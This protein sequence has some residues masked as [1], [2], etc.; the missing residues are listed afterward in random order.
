MVAMK[1][2]ESKH[3]YLEEK[4]S[5]TLKEKDLAYDQARELQGQ[6]RTKNEEYEDAIQSHQLKMNSCEKQISS[7]QEKNQFMEEM[8]QQEQQE[9]LS[10]SISIAILENSLADEK[11]K[12]VVL[13]TECQ[14][15][16]EANRSS[17]MLV[18]ELM[19]ES[20]NH[21]EERKTL[22]ACIG[23]LRGAISQ[24]MKV[25]SINKD[26]LPADFAQD[27]VM[28]QTFSDV[29]LNILKLKEECEDMNWL[30]YTELSVLSTLLSQ[31]GMELKDL[32]LQ[33]LALEKEVENR[34]AESHSLQNKQHLVLEQNEQLSQELQKSNEREEV[35]K[36]EIVFIQE[37]LSYLRESYQTSQNEIS[38]LTNKNEFTSKELQSLSKRCN[39]LEEENSDFLAE[40]MMLEH[41]CLFFKGHNNEVA[42]ALVSLTDEMALLNLV[43]GDL[44]L[45]VNEL[46]RRSMVLESENNHLKEYFIYLLEILRSRVVLSEFDLNTNNNICQEL[47]IELESCFAQLMQKDDEL[48]E[49]EEKVR[50]LQEKNR[51]LCGLVGSLQVAIEGAK[52]VKGELEKKLQH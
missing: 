6:L 13:F 14:K 46:N 15:H 27:V 44:D 52:V 22:L 36:T 29:T 32:H 40:C 49:A 20:R 3:A 43:K 28:L 21:E 23:K 30:M 9:N 51:E 5:S 37:K 19:E 7:L 34:I 39:S 24:Q 35:L 2:L 17:N 41:L 1:T 25:L 18:S 50:F 33:K 45:K 42:S 8:L 11:D 47:A 31:V 38:N 48:L 26:L 10:A 12:K 16:A 4:H